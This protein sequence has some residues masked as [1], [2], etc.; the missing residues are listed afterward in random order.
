MGRN[1]LQKAGTC[2]RSRPKEE[3]VLEDIVLRRVKLPGPMSIEEG[4]LPTPGRSAR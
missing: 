3:H 2:H 4:C 1:E